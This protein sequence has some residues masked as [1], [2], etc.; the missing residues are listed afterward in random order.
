MIL[1]AQIAKGLTAIDALRKMRFAHLKVTGLT[2]KLPF[3]AAPYTA[4]SVCSL[5]TQ[6]AAIVGE[7]AERAAASWISMWLC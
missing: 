7:D 4:W 3:V 2:A 5:G 6:P 1:D